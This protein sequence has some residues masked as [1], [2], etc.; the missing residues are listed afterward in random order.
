MPGGFGRF[1]QK[2]N[3]ADTAAFAGS[4]SPDDSAAANEGSGDAAKTPCIEIRGGTITII[5]ET[6]R[7]ADGLDSNGDIRISGGTVRI[8]LVNS[9]SNCAIDYGSESG[10]VCEITGGN[11]IACGSS[12]MAEGF[13]STSTQ[14]SVL[15]SISGGAEAGTVFS[16]ED[17]DGSVLVSWEVPCSYSSVNVSIPEF[18]QGESYLLVA[19]DSAE[20]I[21]LDEVSASCGDAAGTMFGGSLNQGGMRKPDSSSDASGGNPDGF[22]GGHHRSDSAEDLDPEEMGEMPEGPEPPEIGE[23]P[24]GLE[25]PGTEEMPEGLDPAADPASAA[26]A[27][28]AGGSVLITD[29]GARTW[30]LLGVSSA[31]LFIAILYARRSRLRMR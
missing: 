5:N 6:A 19:G 2:D 16:V 13:D 17:T 22:R 11:V 14:Y 10:G 26:A 30:I 8:S 1:S 3:S 25:P 9:G 18:T 29:F 7:D 28:V 12:S 21:T 24:G 15:Y 23:M 31:A 4:G 20:E 27:S